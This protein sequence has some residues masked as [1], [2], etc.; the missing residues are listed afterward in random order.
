ML[1]LNHR[2]QIL[3]KK[4]IFIC[5]ELVIFLKGKV[6]NIMNVQEKESGGIQ[7]YCIYAMEKYFT[8]KDYDFEEYVVRNIWK[9]AFSVN[10][11]KENEDG[12]NSI[13]SIL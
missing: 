2:H 5:K 12:L 1:C 8:I 3:L 9:T 11:K 13:V 6:K 4:N 10:W 7:E